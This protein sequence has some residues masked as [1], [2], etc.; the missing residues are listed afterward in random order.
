[1]E[2]KEIYLLITSVSVTFL[3]FSISLIALFLLYHKRKDYY[4]KEITKT[5]I[6]IAEQTLRNI[7]WEIHDNIGQILSTLNLYSYKVQEE[8]PVEL[9]PKVNEL[10][11]LIQTAITEVRSLSKAL[12]TEY[13]KNV[14]LIKSLELE[15]AR[16][17]RL[18]F[19]DT[20]LT[21]DGTPFIIPDDKEL[22]L[23]RIIQEFFSN[24]LKH[25]RAT[26]MEIAFIFNGRDLTIT[27]KDNG[28]GYDSTAV[29]GTGIINM[30]NRAKLIG[31]F[32]NLDSEINKGTRLEITYRKKTT[33]NVA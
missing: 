33:D 9:K 24:S 25:A 1:M 19:M 11:D 29:L 18:K 12:N 5:K 8:A 23:L 26:K 4:Q 2:Q 6:E 14:G 28:V 17:E 16:F 3:V 22:V 10:Q 30:R 27:V 21:V 20:Q 13:I 32:I 7:S 31:A 15:L